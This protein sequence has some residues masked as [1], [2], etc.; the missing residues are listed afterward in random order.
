MDV[1]S[2]T[3]QHIQV[4]LFGADSYTTDFLVTANKAARGS[5]HDTWGFMTVRAAVVAETTKSKKEATKRA[6]D[7][8][9]R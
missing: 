5:Q 6:T 4:D 9:A 7:L 1:D 3:E 2:L 8:A